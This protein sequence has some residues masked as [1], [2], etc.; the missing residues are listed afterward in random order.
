MLQHESRISSERMM[1]R[2][3]VTCT[4]AQIASEC[5]EETLKFLDGK[6]IVITGAGSGLGAAYAKHAGMLGGEL[7]LNDV[8]PQA[9]EGIAA[10]IRS[11]GGKAA[12]F[13]GS[14]GSW[15][16][17]EALIDA[18]ARE[19]GRIDGLINNAGILRHGRVTEV[20]EQ[21]FRDMLDVNAIGA[22]GCAA[23]AARRMLKQGTPASIVNVASGSQAGDIALGAYGASKAAVASLTYSWAMELRGT[24]V[25]VNAMSPLAS[26]AMAG[27][28]MQYLAQQSANRD[29]VYTTLPAAEISAPLA[30]FLLSDRSIGVNG[31]LVRIAGDELSFVT[32]PLIAQPV[33]KGTW[34]DDAI[35]EA[36]RTVLMLRQCKLGLAYEQLI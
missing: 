25:R 8:N 36:F 11:A 12:T 33:L 2:R 21:D 27:A 5:M 9:V 4:M 1:Q 13:P 22:A 18:C 15:D 19:Y 20:T 10:E 3:A 14:I 26:T 17:A 35:D 32:H 31:Q 7:L 34:T 23:H 29:V 24:H 28:N 16:Y 6:A 30:T